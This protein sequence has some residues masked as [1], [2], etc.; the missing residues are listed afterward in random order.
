MV[1]VCVRLMRRSDYVRIVGVCRDWSP[2]WAFFLRFRGDCWV[3]VWRLVVGCVWGLFMVFFGWCKSNCAN[4]ILMNDFVDI[5]KSWVTFLRVKFDVFVSSFFG[6]FESFR[7]VCFYFYLLYWSW[8]I[9]MWNYRNN[10]MKTI[11]LLV[12]MWTIIIRIDQKNKIKKDFAIF[13]HN[14]HSKNYKYV[15]QYTNSWQIQLWGWS[16]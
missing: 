10:E 5:E 6:F 3:D 13:S 16:N 1:C 8:I 7:V 12:V 9:Y 15:K 2:V 4:L 14:T 11:S